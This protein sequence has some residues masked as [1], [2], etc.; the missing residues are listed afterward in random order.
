MKLIGTR[1][2]KNGVEYLKIDKTD[3]KIKSARLIVYFHNLF[4]GN[5]ALEKTANEVINQNINQL[6]ADIYPTV[7]QVMAKKIFKIS[8]QIFAKDP[9]DEFFPL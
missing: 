9:Y 3:V 4:K 5:K 8:N 1:Y 7:E 6:A 2:L